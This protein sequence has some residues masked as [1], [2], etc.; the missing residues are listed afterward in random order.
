MVTFYALSELWGDALTTMGLPPCLS[1]T[2]TIVAATFSDPPDPAPDTDGNYPAP[3]PP[4]MGEMLSPGRYRVEL[5]V[6]HE[7]ADA[8]RDAGYEVE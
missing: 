7:W 4:S 1:R 8:L 2:T 5:D 3:L 6:E